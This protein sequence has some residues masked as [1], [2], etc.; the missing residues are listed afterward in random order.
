MLLAHDSSRPPQRQR[1]V[2]FWHSVAPLVRR[3]CYILWSAGV[4]FF[5]LGY[6]GDEYGWWDSRPFAANVVSSATTGLFAVPIALIFLQKLSAH[7]AELS[8]QASVAKH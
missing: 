4:V 8:E 6:L 2:A 7:Q 1:L 5:V 3:T